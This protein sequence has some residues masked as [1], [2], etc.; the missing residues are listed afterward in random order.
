MNNKKR[1]YVPMAVDI[2]HTGHLNIIEVARNLGD[3]TIGLLTD[4]AIVNYK[5]LPMLEF[6]K[7]KK[8]V[9]NIKGVKSIV[10]QDTYDYEPI[11]KKLK[12]DYLVHGD[13]W[14]TGFQSQM[15]KKIIKLLDEWGGKLVEPEYTKGISSTA[16]IDEINKNGITADT[17]RRSLNRLLTVKPLVRIIEAHTGLTGLI[18][19]KTYIE[20]DG[21]RIEFDGIWESSL[22]DSTIKGKPDTELVDFSSRFST[23]EEILEVTTKPIIVDGDTG[24]R[25]EHFKF[26]VKTLDRLGVSAVIIEDKIGAKRNSLF[27][28]EVQQNQDEIENF[29]S[30]ISEGKKAQVSSDFMIIARIES[31]ILKEGMENALK[32]AK[33][34]IG[35]G[36]DGIM[37][38][39]K[40]KDGK[41]IIEFCNKFQKFQNRVPLIVVPS[42]YHHMTENELQDLGVNVV[43]YANHLL[44][45]AYPTMVNTAKSILEH[46]RAKEASEK[47][48]MPIKDIITLIPGGD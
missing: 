48:C 12:P 13:D 3:V 6:E 41:E 26:R 22:T 39:S 15:R 40:E 34:Y 9:E 32:R 16:L 38:H 20:K 36:A 46:G 29:C 24:G 2:L 21:K 8:I 25:I 31:L 30:K 43:I 19:E 7:R 35:A 33:A 11:L 28:T 18:A 23:I 17:R 37:I 27:G 5:R 47:Y 1:V 14:K 4:E 10:T 44:R 42:T 45:A